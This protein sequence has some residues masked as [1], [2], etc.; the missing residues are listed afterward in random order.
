MAL[1]G[2]VLLAKVQ[3]HLDAHTWTVLPT[4]VELRVA[5]SADHGGIIG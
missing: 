4:D 5:R 3:K 1:S 2:D